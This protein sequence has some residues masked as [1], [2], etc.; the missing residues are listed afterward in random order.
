MQVSDC[1]GRGRI[2]VDHAPFDIGHHGLRVQIVMHLLHVEH[3]L[4]LSAAGL[5][6]MIVEIGAQVH[7]A[8]AERKKRVVEI[9]EIGIVLVDQVADP[10]V[11]I[12][13]VRRIRQVGNRVLAAIK[14]FRVEV[15]PPLAL[16]VRGGEHAIVGDSGERALAVAK[17]RDL[18]PPPVSRRMDGDAE[19]HSPLAGRGRPAAEHVP[20]RS[21]VDRIPDM[22]F[23]VPGIEAIVVI[24]QTEE[25]LGPGRLIARHEGI[26]VPIL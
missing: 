6:V 4:H 11:E 18:H 1:Q 8:P 17:P 24:R 20:L 10:V 3:R 26:G 21:E 22:V 15:L 25:E 14:N 7:P 16:A 5:Q 9:E 12:L 13:H 2:L 19:A 23:R